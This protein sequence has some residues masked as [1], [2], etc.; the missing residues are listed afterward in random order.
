[1]NEQ[2]NIRAARERLQD[3]RDDLDL[4]AAPPMRVAVGDLMGTALRN[5]I[6]DHQRRM[7]QALRPPCIRVPVLPPSLSK[8]REAKVARENAMMRDLALMRQRAEQAEE[9]ERD[10]GER[11]EQ[12]E[13]FIVK[14]TIV[15]VAFGA[16]GTAAAI[17]AV[18]LAV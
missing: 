15:L 12:R 3:L 7:D 13:R 4:A 2:Q 1:M 6:R 9:R 8:A 16:L 5:L 11:A 18:I 14:L 10:A 17:A